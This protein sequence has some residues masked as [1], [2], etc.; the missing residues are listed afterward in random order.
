M[1]AAARFTKADVKRAVSGV[2]A[3]GF[4][5][6]AVEIDV[7]GKIRIITSS[8]SKRTPKGWPGLE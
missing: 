5:V 1:T 8:E 6:G 2:A 3:A 4:T 7:N